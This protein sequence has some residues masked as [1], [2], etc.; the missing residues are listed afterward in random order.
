[1]TEIIEDLEQ[2]TD[3]K[4]LDISCEWKVYH[5]DDDED[6]KFS[7]YASIFGNKDLGNDIVEKGAFSSTLRKKS[8]K[9]I[10]MLFMHKTDEP[11]T[12]SRLRP[13]TVR[14]IACRHRAHR[15]YR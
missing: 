7:G 5:D 11:G 1:M 9:Q 4:Y 12:Q 6:G 15:V 2:N 13:R 14:S 3:T 10:K 8:P